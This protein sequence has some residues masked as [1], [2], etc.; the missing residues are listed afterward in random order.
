MPT[1]EQSLWHMRPPLS[2]FA[3]YWAITLG[4]LWQHMPDFDLI[5]SHL[6]YFAF[7]TA[8]AAVEPGLTT[9]HGRL[10]IPGLQELYRRFRD[11]PLVSISDAQREPI[12]DANRL[13]TV[14]NGIELNEFTF[15][16]RMGGYV[17]FL[18]SISPEKGLDVAIRVARRAGGA[19]ADWCA[20]CPPHTH[21]PNVR[22]DWEYWED[23]IQPLLEGRQVERPDNSPADKDDLLGGAAALLFPIHWPEPFGLA[24]VEALACGTPVP[25]LNRGSVPEVIEDGVT[26]FIRDSEDELVEALLHISDLDRARR[27]AEAER[28]FSSATMA[29]AYE[30]VYAQLLG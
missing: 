18:G 30:R 14:Y 16:P 6:D 24:M 1:V 12:P 21:D 23:E 20:T 22:A 26:G 2:D 3:P 13:G 9:L 28:G 10:D 29:D 25:A 8:R 15:N 7:P 19:A 17:A 5:H 27:R 4:H 11:V